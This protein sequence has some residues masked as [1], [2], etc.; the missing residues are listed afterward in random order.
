MVVLS[1]SLAAVLT[2]LVSLLLTP[3]DFRVAHRLGAIDVP[4]DGRRM[5]SR[6]VPR[7]GGIS[8]FFASLLFSLIFCFSI[9]EALFFGWA[10]AI[11]IVCVGVLDDVLA[12]P[13]WIKLV[14]QV[15]A[16]YVSTIGGNVI[17]EMGGVRLG[18][19]SLPLT[20]LFT[21]TLINAHNFIDG[22]DGLCGGVALVEGAALGLIGLTS[23]KP[24]L[25]IA[26]FILCGACIGFL[27]Y[28]TGGARIFMGDCGSTFLGFALAW[29]SVAL[30]ADPS[31]ISPISLLLIFAI[32]LADITVAVLRRVAKGK[33]PFL[34]DRSH[35]HHILSD[36][37][38]GHLGASRLLRLAA[39]LFAAVGYLIAN[40]I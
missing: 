38:L 17:T 30:L 10:G 9:A 4:K 39:A 35:I 33:S 24:R 7:L 34:P 26:A 12:L 11:L 37:S 23:G 15:G 32:P 14:S 25:A 3:F 28:N 6:P 21:V 2:A 27:P 13:P 8:I 31:P 22:L 16:A 18:V 20:L 36:T 29:V 1:L 5:H 19:A 40:K